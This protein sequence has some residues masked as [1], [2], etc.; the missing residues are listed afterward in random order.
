MSDRKK[1]SSLTLVVLGVAVVAGV[2]TFVKYQM[3]VNAQNKAAQDQVVSSAP[4]TAEATTTAATTT[5]ADSTP[6]TPAS[7]N[8]ELPSAINTAEAPAAEPAPPA[9]TFTDEENAKFVTPRILGNP[10]APVRISEHS[11]FTCGACKMFHENNFKKI[12]AEYVDTGKA[13][14][15]YNDFSRNGIDVYAGSLARCIEGDEAYFNFVQLLFEKQTEWANPELFEKN[16]KQNAMI[17]GVSAD[18]ADACMKNEKVHEALAKQ[19]QDAQD[20]FGINSTPHLVLNNEKVVAGLA[21]YEE[22][23]AAIEE[24]L[25][26]NASGAPATA[27]PAAEQP[28]Q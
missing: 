8:E 14:I 4:A 16:L 13:Y 12:K 23:K 1:K 22:I 19:V 11:S 7:P 15:V 18:R 17:A 5:V 28:K 21:P 24:Q 3:D 25:A 6:P 20:K 10:N 2:A 27:T 9:V 26:K